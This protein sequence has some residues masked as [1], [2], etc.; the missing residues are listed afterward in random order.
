MRARRRRGATGMHALCRGS[1]SPSP[2]LLYMFQ[3]RLAIMGTE[4]A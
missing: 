2:Q 1:P 4:P 3:I